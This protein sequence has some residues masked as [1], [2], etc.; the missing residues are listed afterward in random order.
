MELFKIMLNMCR[1]LILPILL[2]TLFRNHSTDV[3]FKAYFYILCVFPLYQCA[4]ESQ[5]S[6]WN[7]L[8]VK[9]Y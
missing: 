6:P 4:Q 9:H 1:T 8:H 5:P 2:S 7:G 3:S